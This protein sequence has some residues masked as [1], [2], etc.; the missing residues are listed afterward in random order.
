[1]SG[2]QRG[3]L[4]I[5]M[6]YAAGVGKTY[7]MLEEAHELKA[8][9]LDV[10]VGYFEAH[11]RKDTIAKIEGLEIVPRKKVEYRGSVLRG[12][13]YRCHPRAPSP[14]LRGG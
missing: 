5:Y 14:R 2:N 9:G 1:M 12:D 3:K 6:G 11:G 4:K 8:R 10:V 7:P 13:G